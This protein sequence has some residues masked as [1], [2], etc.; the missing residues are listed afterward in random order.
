MW[1]VVR[2]A[3]SAAAA[4]FPPCA[5]VDWDMPFDAVEP[6]V[7]AR[8]PRG[9][10]MSKGEPG[11]HVTLDGIDVFV[12]YPNRTSALEE[13]QFYS[14]EPTAGA[15]RS[16][17]AALTR[18]L[19]PPVQ[20]AR[21]DLSLRW[22]LDDQHR[23]PSASLRVMQEADGGWRVIETLERGGELWEADEIVREL[24]LE[25]SAGPVGW[26]DLTWG[27]PGGEVDLAMK[28]LG[29]SVHRGHDPT[30]CDALSRP[31]MGTCGRAY[32]L[33]AGPAVLYIHETRG[34]S[35]VHIDRV[36]LTRAEALAARAE[37]EAVLGPPTSVE[38]HQRYTFRAQG[39]QAELWMYPRGFQGS[40][41]R[42]R[43]TPPR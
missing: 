26:L 37:I 22:S 6:L 17:L 9:A 5:V 29:Y 32:T 27:M 35:S 15:G 7:N 1:I 10:H 13:I 2:V 31:V 14:T 42:I 11:V 38:D 18:W 25:F 39:T 8:W 30:P 12:A 16:V 41:R 19:G 20:V 40:C 3:A 34:L 36:V 28:A 4:P 33:V 21:T 43:W 23:A 24:H